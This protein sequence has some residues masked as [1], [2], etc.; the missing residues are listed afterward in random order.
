MNK[1]RFSVAAEQGKTCKYCGTDYMESENF[2]WSCRTHKSEF[3][4]ELWWC[5]GKTQKE[6]VGC[7][8]DKHQMRNEAE[9]NEDGTDGQNA[10]KNKEV[11]NCCK[12]LGHRADRCDNDPNFHTTPGCIEQLEV[13]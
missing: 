10:V 7:K 8:F 13:Q 9:E 2:N 1:T 4:G 3:S 11:C 12:E 5:C 6:A